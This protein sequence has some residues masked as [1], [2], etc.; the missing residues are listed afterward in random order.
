MMTLRKDAENSTHR[1]P[2]HSVCFVFL[3][4]KPE[5]R[6]VTNQSQVKVFNTQTPH[7]Y[8]GSAQEAWSL[9]QSEQH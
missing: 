6:A 1:F 4:L 7:A 5:E 9:I 2:S 3:T 8:W